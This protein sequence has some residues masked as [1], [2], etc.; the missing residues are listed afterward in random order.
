MKLEKLI[1]DSTCLREEKYRMKP[2]VWHN[3]LTFKPLLRGKLLK[4]FRKR[5]RKRKRNR[6]SI[7]ETVVKAIERGITFIPHRYKEFTIQRTLHIQSFVKEVFN[8][9]YALL[10]PSRGVKLTG[11]EMDA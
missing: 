2:D 1:E 8:T 6:I 4:S 5:K 9:V 3:E 11:L 10:Q 7:D